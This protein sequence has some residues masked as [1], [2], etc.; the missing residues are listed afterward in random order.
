MPRRLLAIVAAVTIGTTLWVATP[1]FAGDVA[2]PSFTI[3]PTEGPPGTVITVNGTGCATDDSTEV[4]V[5]LFVPD[6]SSK[7]DTDL[8]PAEGLNGTWTAHVTVPADTVLY[9]DWHV[10]AICYLDL[11]E[12]NA[13]QTDELFE[14]P[15]DQ[16]FTVLAPAAE[17]QPA[18]AP[19]PEAPAPA[20]V[21]AAVDFTG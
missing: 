14:Y 1:S 5:S 17:P 21:E 2:E 12:V 18:P 10:A 19:T 4:E 6:G 15:D 3:T 8:V 13:A 9:G 16:D 7:A 20:P 11:P